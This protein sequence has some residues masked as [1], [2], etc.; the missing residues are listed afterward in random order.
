MDG[1]RVLDLYAGT[2]ALGIEALSRGAAEAQFMEVDPVRCEYIRESV[3]SFGFADRSRVTRG[4]VSRMLQRIRGRY[5]LVFV[6][7]PYAV[8]PWGAVMRGLQ[9]RE[10]LEGGALVVAEHAKSR[11]LADR[12]GDLEIW[13]R[14]QYGDSMVSIYRN[15]A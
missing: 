1:A 2:G 9:D 13:K 6:D 14:R 8:D 3:R 12:Y 7:P 11:G 5:D 10:L 15:G 4:D